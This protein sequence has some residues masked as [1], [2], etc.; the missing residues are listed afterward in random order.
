MD[1]NKTSV[2]YETNYDQDLMVKE[3]QGTPPLCSQDHIYAC[4]ITLFFLLA[5]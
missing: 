1:Q 5:K 4:L 2:G 3:Q